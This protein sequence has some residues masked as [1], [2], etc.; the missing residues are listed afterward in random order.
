MLSSP[1]SVTASVTPY[2]S[3]SASAI[4]KLQHQQHT[5]RCAV[6]YRTIQVLVHCSSSSS[7]QQQLQGTLHRREPTLQHKGVCFH[8]HRAPSSDG[9]S[10][11]LIPNGLQRPGRQSVAPRAVP[12]DATQ[13]SSME[14]L[15]PQA[16]DSLAGDYGSLPTP[17]LPSGAAV[18]QAAR[19]PSTQGYSSASAGAAQQAINAGHDHQYRVQLTGQ[20]RQQLKELLLQQQQLQQVLDATA[21]AQAGSSG[22]KRSKLRAAAAGS[23]DLLLS[24]LQ[25][26]LPLLTGQVGVGAA[27]VD[28][29]EPA[30]SLSQQQ[31]APTNRQQGRKQQQRPGAPA[32]VPLLAEALNTISWHCRRQQLLPGEA[33]RLQAIMLQ[34]LLPALGPHLHLVN[35]RQLARVVFALGSCASST[36]QEEQQGLEQ[37]SAAQGTPEGASIASSATA[38]ADP[39]DGSRSSSR[40]AA[41]SAAWVRRLLP[42]LPPSSLTAGG[43]LAVCQGCAL[44]G[45]VP[46]DSWLQGAAW[47]LHGHL[48]RGKLDFNDT[49]GLLQACAALDFSPPGW[50]M[51]PLVAALQQQLGLL[52]PA[53]LAGRWGCTQQEGRCRYTPGLART[54]ARACDCCRATR[55]VLQRAAAVVAD[56]L[57]SG[58]RLD[59]SQNSHCVQAACFLPCIISALTLPLWVW[60]ACCWVCVEGG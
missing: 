27:T 37:T 18:Q 4:H 1:I 58:G 25:S 34:H 36:W 51:M 21:G 47:A 17:G 33:G 26:Q 30:S 54:R 38:A 3:P 5:P 55:G 53:D 48:V 24:L 44:Q 11:G 13:P 31:Q 29:F 35:K 20:F 49:A 52:T 16:A 28:D 32:H 45:V 14:G 40:R 59:S 7:S 9:L 8:K 2:R 10:Y 23:T 39:A 15:S 57:P 19:L 60:T 46:P 22:K 43:L 50:L 6:L 41:A 12:D 56:C 42:L